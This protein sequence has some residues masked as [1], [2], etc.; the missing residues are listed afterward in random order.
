MTFTTTIESDEPPVIK[1]VSTGG[2]SSGR[3]YLPKAWIGQS[4]TVILERKA[5][6]GSAG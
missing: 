6:D 2:K 1:T 3:I 5:T 4:V